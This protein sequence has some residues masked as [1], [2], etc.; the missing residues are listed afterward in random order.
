MARLQ[1]MQINVYGLC[2]T[3]IYPA[4]NAGPLRFDIMKFYCTKIKER[5]RI[6]GGNTVQTTSVELAKL[7]KTDLI[8]KVRDGTYLWGLRGLTVQTTEMT[9]VN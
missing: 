6:Y 9:L 3:Q 2:R 8:I 5:G 7:F 1:S 4:V